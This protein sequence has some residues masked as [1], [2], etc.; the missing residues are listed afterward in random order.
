MTF[1]IGS[2]V[3]AE[4]LTPTTTPDVILWTSS[5][6]STGALQT[7]TSSD[8]HGV[9]RS[10]DRKH[11][12]GY[13]Y[14][15]NGNYVIYL[16]GKPIREFTSY[17]SQIFFL[18]NSL[19][20]LSTEYDSDTWESIY[21]L[22]KDNQ[23]Y[24][25]AEKIE[26]SDA[27]KYG[28]T[29]YIVIQ[30]DGVV[31]LSTARWKQLLKVADVSYFYSSYLPILDIMRISLTMKD[32]TTRVYL[33]DTLVSWVS[34]VS[35]P[36]WMIQSGDT[37]KVLFRAYQLS[38]DTSGYTYRFFFYNLKTKEITFPFNWY[39]QNNEWYEVPYQV[40]TDDR[41]LISQLWYIVRTD[42]NTYAVVDGLKGSIVY[43][44]LWSEP[45]LFTYGSS[46]GMTFTKNRKYFLLIESKTYGPYDAIGTFQNSDLVALQQSNQSDWWMVVRK[47]HKNFLLMN[48]KEYAF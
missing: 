17:P 13:G 33:G 45:S 16:D 42:E 36:L 40:V 46:I 30:N 11:W 39:S 29:R 4:V 48:G 20:F 26:I 41:G 3:F 43:P 22:W 2:S 19:F 9:V 38:S 37:K 14:A 32:G 1:L 47:N 7:V 28:Q 18:Q 21:I 24:I 8:A 31:T 6:V 23:E 35:D 12:A 5:Q 15:E 34:E 25:R 10:Q 44:D 27:V